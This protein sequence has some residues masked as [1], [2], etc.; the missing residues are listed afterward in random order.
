MSV[1]TFSDFKSHA[2]N[3]ILST[4]GLLQF[5]ERAFASARLFASFCLCGSYVNL[6]DWFS[7]LILSS[8]A[9]VLSS[10]IK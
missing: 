4:A 10:A 5:T 6:T 1:F 3:P 7:A 2:S 9:C 8:L